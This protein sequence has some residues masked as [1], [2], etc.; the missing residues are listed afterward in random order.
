VSDSFYSNWPVIDINAEFTHKASEANAIG[1][2]LW[3]DSANNC[4]R[5]ASQFPDKG[6]QQAT[7]EAFAAVF[8]GVA[9]SKQLVGDATAEPCR[10]LIDRLWEYPLVSS[11]PTLGSL[12]APNY[13]STGLGVVGCLSPQQLQ[14]VTD[15]TQ[16]IGASIKAYTAA[17]TYV[18][19]RLTS[20]LMMGRYSL[21]GQPA[22]NYN[23]NVFR[24]LIH[25]GDFTANP[26]Q[27]GTSFTGISNTLTYT[28]D[29]WFAVGAST[30][31]IS[32]SQ[33]SQ[34]DVLGFGDSLRWGR[35]NTDTAA[36]YLGQVLETLDSQRVQGREVTL[37]F[38]AK[39]GA[40]FSGGTVTVQLNHSTTA[41]NDSAAHLKAASTNWQATPTIIN[42]TFTPTTTV[43]RFTFTGVVPSGCTQLGLLFSYTPSGS[44]DSTDTVDFYGVQLEDGAVASN[45]E[46]RPA[47]IELDLCQRFFVQFNE[48]AST[49]VLAPGMITAAAVQVFVIPLPVPMLSTPTITVSVGTFKVNLAGTATTPTTFA[50]G[51]G[52]INTAV[53]TSAN[54]GQTAGQASLLQGGGGSG[55]VRAS[56]D[57]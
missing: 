13:T 29:R 9:N 36:I 16:A 30:S 41:G 54:T 26:W 27:R 25:G 21:E 22:A 1:D 55:Y 23:W 7:L 8:A 10:D 43:Q 57:L 14:I 28:A 38:W 42:A 35:A 51:T 15:P 52:T 18:K 24:N 2:L 46:H 20:S 12:L 37:S 3:W 17:T 31:S 49:V 5:S 39:A 6:S 34:T 47:Q 33:Q 48:P 44:N 4:L 53:V 40:Q 50:A 45:F 32:V 11:T 56:A 19:C